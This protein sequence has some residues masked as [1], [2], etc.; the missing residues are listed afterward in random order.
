[1]SARKPAAPASRSPR[2]AR[3]PR[4]AAAR[5]EAAA[6]DLRACE[7]DTVDA[8]FLESL[9]GYNVRRASLA[10]VAVFMQ[11]TERFELKI[12]EFSVLSLVGANPGITSRQLCQQ[13]DMLP[14][15]MVGMI[16]ALSARGYMERR[17]HPRD[18]RA[19]GL[20]LT[21]QGRELVDA[22][23]PQLK[24]GEQQAVQQRLSAQ[25]Q[26]QLLALLQKLYR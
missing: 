8:G 2:A 19:T 10:L 5:E 14:P 20:Y 12:V 7:V 13:L 3:A 17:P 15:N 26:A 4:S 24:A 23:Q 6:P 18:G 22:A 9:V 16:D 11:C 25:E 21:P 1:M